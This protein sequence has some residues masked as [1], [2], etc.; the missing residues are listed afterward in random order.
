MILAHLL[1][2]TLALTAYSAVVVNPVN[3]ITTNNLM[4]TGTI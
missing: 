4:F 1:I 3:G 2:A